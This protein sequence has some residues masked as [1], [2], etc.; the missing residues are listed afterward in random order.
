MFCI[1]LKSDYYL[2]QMLLISKI[3]SVGV[4]KIPSELKFKTNSL[5]GKLERGVPSQHHLLLNLEAL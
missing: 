1:I 3:A 2:H 4:E 5:A